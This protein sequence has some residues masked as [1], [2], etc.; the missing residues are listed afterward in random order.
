MGTDSCTG[1]RDICAA[2]AALMDEMLPIACTT[3]FEQ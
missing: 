1:I 3:G 2:T